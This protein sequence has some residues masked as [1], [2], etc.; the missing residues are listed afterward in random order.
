MLPSFSTTPFP[1]ELLSLRATPN[2]DTKS[3]VVD[4][5]TASE[6]NNAGFHLQRSVDGTNFNNI[7]WI[8]GQGTTQQQHTYVYDDKDVVFNQKYYYRLDQRDLNGASTI[9]NVV[10]AILFS[11]ESFNVV[12]YP[13]PAQNFV[14]MDIQ[15]L[16]D[17]EFEWILYNALGQEV[18]KSN[19]KITKGTQTLEIP[20][21]GLSNGTYQLQMKSQDFMKGIKL[22]KVQ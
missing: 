3:I 22:V 6:F 16:E 15:S 5:I 2:Y 7:A 20:L 1:V 14:R 9:S 21:T 8:D 10:E 4:W 13:N 11:Q 17:R 18:L 12:V 19:Q